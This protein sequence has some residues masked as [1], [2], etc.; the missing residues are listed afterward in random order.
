MN[1]KVG[2]NAGTYLAIFLDDLPLDKAGHEYVHIITKYMHQDF[3]G[4]KMGIAH[5]DDLMGDLTASPDMF[6][7]DRNSQPTVLI[8]IRYPQGTDSDKMNHQMQAALGD[9]VQVITNPGDEVPHYVPQDD[10]LVENIV[11]GL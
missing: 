8:N 5:H 9:A 4:A 10:P 2:K 11:E 3:D 6:N 7:F 1:P